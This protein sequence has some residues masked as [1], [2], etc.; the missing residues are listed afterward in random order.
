MGDRS[1]S[2]EAGLR[3]NINKKHNLSLDPAN[4]PRVRWRCH[5]ESASLK[6]PGTGEK[7]NSDYLD[8]I[9]SRIEQLWPG[10]LINYKT[11][12]PQSTS[13]VNLLTYSS[14]WCERDMKW[15][16]KSPKNIFKYRRM[17]V[18][19]Y[20]GCKSR[21]VQRF[22]KWLDD[23]YFSIWKTNSISFPIHSAI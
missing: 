5:G 19:R 16:D 21:D 1:Q 12:S 23:S 22:S 9:A 6:Y 20:F 7:R 14:L 10:F 4:L 8:I 17:S 2:E 11:A 18:W 13:T 3:I 15:V